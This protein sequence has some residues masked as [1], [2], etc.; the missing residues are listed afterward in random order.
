MSKPSTVKVIGYTLGTYPHVFEGE[1]IGDDSPPAIGTKF[2][3]SGQFKPFLR[4]I[5]AEH[6]EYFPHYR[7]TIANIMNVFPKTSHGW[8][9]GRQGFWSGQTFVPRSSI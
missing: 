6:L 2:N 3:R 7:Y 5:L 4:T 8:T 1:I 9:K